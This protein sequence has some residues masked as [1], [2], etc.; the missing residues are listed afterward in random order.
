[1]KI[2]QKVLK[3]M[4]GTD[5]SVI[6][7]RTERAIDITLAEVGKGINKIL[8]NAR[9]KVNEEIKD[10]QSIAHSHTTINQIENGIKKE[11]RK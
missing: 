9:R 8:T 10:E 7:K 11:L 3:E 4:Y 5:K 2:K 1:M 6:A